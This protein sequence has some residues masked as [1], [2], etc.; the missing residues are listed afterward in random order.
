MWLRKKN[1]KSVIRFHSA[2]KVNYNRGG[3]QRK[4]SKRIYRTSQNIRI[5]NVFL[6][7]LLSESFP[8]LQ[9]IVHLTS[10]GCPPPL[11]WSLDLLWG[12][13]RLCSGPTPVCSRLQCP[14]LSE[15]V[16]FLLWELSV[17]FYIFHRHRVCLVDHVDLICSLDSWWEDFGSSSL[18]T[19]RLGFS[20]GF[21]STSTEAALESLGLPLW[22]PGVEVVQLLGSQGFMAA[23]GTQGSWQLGQ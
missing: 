1:L 6:E 12:Q 17:T 8:W 22:G 10:L 2:N 11:C 13:L 15:L 3:K 20:C 5:T 23:P 18:A 4:K 9:V 14:Q 21:I 16:Y 19:L 7:S